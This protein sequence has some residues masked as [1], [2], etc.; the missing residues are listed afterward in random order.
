M[1]HKK[2]EDILV[3]LYR[4][5]QL[6]TEATSARSAY[7]VI[8]D[9]IL[10][11]F[12]PT[13]ASI[14]LISPNS[15]LLEKEF[16]HGYPDNLDELSIHLGK[17]LIG[18]VAFNGSYILCEDTRKDT[19]YVALID[20]VICKMAVPMIAD[21]QIIGV[22]DV[23]S[24]QAGAFN[25]DHLRELQLICEESTRVLQSIWRQRQLVT[26][27]EQLDALLD[28]GQKIVSNLELQGLWDSVAEAAIDLT[29]SKLCTIQLFDSAN[30]QAKLVAMQPQ[31]E[32]F[33]KRASVVNLNDSLASSGIRTKKQAEF[34][35]IRTPDYHSL[36]DVPRAANVASCLSTPMIFE[37]K[38]IGIINIYTRHQHRFTN[39]ER[40]LIQAFASLSAVA[41]ENAT[42]Y[43]RV[44][45]SEELL[46]KTERLTTLGLL[47]AEIAH[48][49][50][51][52]LTVLKLLFGAL[53]LNYEETDPR[54]KDTK[55]INEKINHLEEIVSKVLSFGKAPQ[56]L[57]THHNVSILIQDTC[58]LVR[59]K[60]M[61]QQINLQHGNTDPTCSVNG[62][63]GQIQ[64]VFLNLIINAADAM[65]QGGT[66]TVHAKRELENGRQMC[67][68]YFSDTGTGIP[69]NIQDHIFESFL[70]GKPEGT[71]LGLSIAKRILRDHHGDISVTSSS[72]S[73]TTMRVALPSA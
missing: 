52:P 42:L 21:S 34:P 43:N 17:G 23:D 41:S 49:I 51:N 58:L 62:N 45:K 55:I 61:Q 26:Q 68:I 46:R 19:R 32:E 50:R 6:A 4:I 59:H 67:Y 9:E 66:L 11:R 31:R 10:K 63:K 13:S 35:N 5:S 33:K 30:A 3:C 70:T 29:G 24:D 71:G 16:A 65:P 47:S 25:A 53:D 38:V 60:M 73:G 54:H 20:N 8:I 56:S 7:E 44:V 12:A 22:F 18:R 15:G 57:F 64:Q 14:S 1:P 48:E 39:G 27:S 40:R 28:L 72:P 36:L 69:D 2:P 37:N